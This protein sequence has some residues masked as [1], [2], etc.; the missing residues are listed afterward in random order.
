MTTT[1][2]LI[3]QLELDAKFIP[4]LIGSS[5]LQNLF[6]AS[7][8]RLRELD[9]PDCAWTFDEDQ[10][11]YDTGCGGAWVFPEL[12]KL[13]EHDVKFCPYCGGSVKDAS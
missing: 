8:Q 2:E 9:K 13:A 5:R 6:N 1:I 7:A 4:Q 12:S 3:A 11:M 10:G